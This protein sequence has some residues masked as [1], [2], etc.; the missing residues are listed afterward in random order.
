MSNRAVKISAEKTRAT[1]KLRNGGDG[2]GNG[3][4]QGQPRPR[5]ITEPPPR[6]ESLTFVR[7]SFLFPFECNDRNVAFRK[8]QRT[9]LSV[10]GLGQVC[11]EKI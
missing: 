3:S 8:E 2:G 1:M 7:R 11:L 4:L 10:A 9:L 5:G 6:D